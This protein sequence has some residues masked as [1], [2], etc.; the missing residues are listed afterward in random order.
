MWERAGGVWGVTFPDIVPQK[1]KEDVKTV[2][3][4]NRTPSWPLT[5][6]TSLLLGSPF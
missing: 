4:E 6:G 2:T 5:P 3:N 1:G